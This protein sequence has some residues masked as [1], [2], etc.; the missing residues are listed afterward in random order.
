LV[1]AYDISDKAIDLI[2]NNAQ[3][4]GVEK[5]LT[6]K[7]TPFNIAEYTQESNHRYLII[8][9]IEGGEKGLFSSTNSSFFN[10]SDL[11]IELHDFIDSEIK[12]YIVNLFSETHDIEIIQ[13]SPIPNFKEYTC[14]SE[15]TVKKALHLTDEKRPCR[16]EWAI[17]RSKEYIK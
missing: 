8:C 17:L 6:I 14:L 5:Q 15:T 9:D 1:D 4:N 2:K 11:I 3:I 12:P 7:N 13:E 10:Q 16:M